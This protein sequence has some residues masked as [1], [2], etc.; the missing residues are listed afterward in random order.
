M[1]KNQKY[2]K[3]R[4]E[5]SLPILPEDERIFLNVSY[6]T[7]DFAKYCNCAYD[8]NHKLWFTGCLNSNLNALVEL[9]GINEMTSDKAK[10]LLQQA[11][12]KQRLTLKQEKL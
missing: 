6:R 4:I 7:R 2:W 5:N 11:L 1:K 8:S 9:Y 12:T 3:K 10:T